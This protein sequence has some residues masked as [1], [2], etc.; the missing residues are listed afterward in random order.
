[1]RLPGHPR[2]RLPVLFWA[3]STAAMQRD[4]GRAEALAQEGLNLAT[5]AGHP[6]AEGQLLYSLQLNAYVMDDMNLV[7]ARGEQAVA[8]L[9]EL[10]DIP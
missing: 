1:L 3:A 8:R 10:Q 6:E 7:I 2:Y 5:Q 9:R 4:F